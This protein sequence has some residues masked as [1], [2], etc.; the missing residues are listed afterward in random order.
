MADE[1]VAHHGGTMR[2]RINAEQQSARAQHLRITLAGMQLLLASCMRAGRRRDQ[3]PVGFGC[4][5]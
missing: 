3:Y 1:I 2:E 4:T 5:L